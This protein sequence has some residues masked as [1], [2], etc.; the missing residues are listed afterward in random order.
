MDRRLIIP[1]M[2]VVIMIASA[3]G[4]GYAYSSELS[5]E[6]QI[7]GSTTVE[8]C[9]LSAD[10]ESPL[11]INSLS[12]N[13]W[14][15]SGGTGTD[16]Y[17]SKIQLDYVSK[18]SDGGVVPSLLNVSLTFNGLTITNGSPTKTTLF[19]ELWNNTKS[20]KGSA[21]VDTSSGSTTCVVSGLGPMECTVDNPGTYWIAFHM[22]TDVD[23]TISCGSIIVE[24]NAFPMGAST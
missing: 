12:Q 1:S 2:A 19:V 3:I 6:T 15:S 8:Y 23:C 24:M 9:T 14:I 4:I 5:V 22:E 7:T 20:Y 11:K 10:V 18:T 21:L 13:H 17:S 16:N